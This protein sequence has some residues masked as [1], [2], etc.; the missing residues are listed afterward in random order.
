MY[1]Q[2]SHIPNLSNSSEPFDFV[3]TKISKLTVVFILTIICLALVW[4]AESFAT[5]FIFILL[6]LVSTFES[7][8][9]IF[10]LFVLYV[11]VTNIRLIK[12]ICHV[13][14][15]NDLLRKTVKID[16]SESISRN[17][18]PQPLQILY[19]HNLNYDGHPSWQSSD[20]PCGTLT[21]KATWPFDHMVLQNHIINY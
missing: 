3:L 20:L 12:I 17:L 7:Y 21:D 14:S 5:A 19:L 1:F 2:I 10:L 15:N 8:L 18:S 4:N 16:F 11:R 6:L 13:L 9:C